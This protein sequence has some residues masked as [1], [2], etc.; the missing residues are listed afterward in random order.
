M[1]TFLR[2]P[3]MF[4][5]VRRLSP[6]RSLRTSRS[7]SDSDSNIDLPRTGNFVET[8]TTKIQAGP[9]ICQRDLCRTLRWAPRHDP[10]LERSLVLE[11]ARSLKLPE[12]LPDTGRTT[13]QR[14]RKNHFS[15]SRDTTPI[16]PRP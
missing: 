13:P 8:Q 3:S 2:A 15:R 9:E 16:P 5:S 14:F 1:R 6:L 12:K 4:S 7:L 10:F 11:R